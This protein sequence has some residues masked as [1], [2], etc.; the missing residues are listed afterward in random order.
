MN[1]RPALRGS[2]VVLAI[3]ALL[4]GLTAARAADESFAELVSRLQAEKPPFAERQQKLL[5]DRY[6]LADRPAAGVTM[7]RGKLV[8]DGVRVKLHEGQTWESLAA[9]TPEEIK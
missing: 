3:A 1:F 6:D 8:Q 5:A 4:S 2:A 9:M 7:T